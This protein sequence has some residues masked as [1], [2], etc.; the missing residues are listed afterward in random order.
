MTPFILSEKSREIKRQ[1]LGMH[2][3]ICYPNPAVI[4]SNQPSD[5]EEFRSE[6]RHLGFPERRHSHAERPG[7]EG[8]QN[9]VS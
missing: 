5:C 2:T 6:R 7:P 8:D 3:F 9:H 1:Y 4:E